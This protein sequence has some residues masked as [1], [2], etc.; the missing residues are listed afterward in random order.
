M[1]K[2]ISILLVFICFIF[3]FNGVFASDNIRVI[4]VE[5]VD[6]Y[7][8]KTVLKHYQPYSIGIVNDN[9]TPVLFNAK[10]E[11]KYIDTSGKEYS[12][13]DNAL[14]YKKSRKRDVGRYC[15]ISLP[16]AAV[17]GAIIGITF[18][19]GFI[20]GVGVAIAGLVPTWQGEKYNSKIASNMYIENK[21]P[22]S[23]EP[24]KYY[25][26]YVFLPNENSAQI[27]KIIISDLSMK[28]S[29]PFNLTI[30]LAGGIK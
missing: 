25:M 24:G 21:I 19:L 5:A 23:L 14:V 20:A 11:I 12:F 29:K 17:G 15:W 27:D 30:P 8:Y 3:Q 18:G 28:G 26:L 1:K 16:C 10:S 22:L 13:P 2:L 4:S 9:N 6:G 7:Q